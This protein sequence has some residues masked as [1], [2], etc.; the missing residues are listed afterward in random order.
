MQHLKIDIVSDIV[1][2]WCYIGY[3]QLENA[4]GLM[5]TS[6][7]L[8]LE[9][10]PFELNRT[11]PDVGEG[12][13]EHLQRKYGIEPGAE[14]TQRQ[15]M[16]EMAE[17]LGI[18][19][20]Y[21]EGKRIYNTFRA[22]RILHWAREQ[23]KQSEFKLALF[24]LYFEEGSNPSDLEVLKNVASELSL[25]SCEVEKILNSDRYINDVRAEQ[26]IY[27]SMGIQG[28][29]TFIV[30]DKYPITGAQDATALAQMLDKVCASSVTQSA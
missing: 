15:Q 5:Q 28:V 29:P 18:T 27:T 30:N 22:H 4:I 8:E 14:P 2:P 3:K 9:W 20:R 17:G 26:D 19:M 23:G 21:G 25:D 10:H 6:V 24:K 16:I 11:L 13:A 7:D 1:C 12:I